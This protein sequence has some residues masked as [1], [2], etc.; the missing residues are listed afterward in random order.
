MTKISWVPDSK[1]EELIENAVAKAMDEGY[2]PHQFLAEIKKAWNRGL[3]RHNEA[4]L[5][6]FETVE[7]QQ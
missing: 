1:V 5:A 6:E 7:I 4:T 3:Q 2:R